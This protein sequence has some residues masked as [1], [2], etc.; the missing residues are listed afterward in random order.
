[1][2]ARA[3][4]ILA[5]SIVA[6]CAAGLGAT[7]Q[8]WDR[9]VYKGVT[10]VIRRE[11]PLE[12]YFAEFPKRRVPP[13]PLCTALRRGYC[14]TF[15]IRDLRLI[16]RDVEVR[17]LGDL[18]ASPPAIEW[19]SAVSTVWPYKRPFHADW[20]TGTLALPYGK[21]HVESEWYPLGVY[22]TFMLL[23]I[24][25][26]RLTAVRRVD[27]PRLFAAYRQTEAGR[28]KVAHWLRS[29]KGTPEAWMEPSLRWD[30]LRWA[31]K[32]RDPAVIRRSEGIRQVRV[33]RDL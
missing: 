26:G 15:E 1:M 11:Y 27:L 2:P 20:F 17:N 12:R 4:W 9:I 6:A 28:R 10:Y 23:D 3:A 16:V 19:E 21:R 14:A 7:E 13:R 32:L 22:R 25:R 30:T 31:K 33:I 5:C 24:R 8:I 18:D 29:Y